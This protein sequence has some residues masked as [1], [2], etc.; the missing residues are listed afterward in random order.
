MVVE[1]ERV[2]FMM[3]E[4]DGE[5]V[6]CAVLVEGDLGSISQIPFSVEQETARID[7][8]DTHKNALGTFLIMCIIYFFLYS[9]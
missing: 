8:E 2:E 4:A 5:V 6:V 7:G 3:S 9:Y 1:M